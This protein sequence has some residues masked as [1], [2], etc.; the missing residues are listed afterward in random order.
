MTAALIRI[1]LRWALLPI[2]MMFF[3]P[4]MA[5]TIADEI[6]NSPDIMLLLTAL[7]SVVEGWFVRDKLKARRAKNT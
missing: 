1:F 6:R 4:E 3:A 2:L 5:Q 7:F